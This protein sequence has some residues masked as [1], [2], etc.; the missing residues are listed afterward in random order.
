MNYKEYIDDENINVNMYNFEYW[1]PIYKSLTIQSK[2]IKLPLSILYFFKENSIYT[3]NIPIYLGNSIYNEIIKVID[4]Y[5]SVFPKLYNKCCYDGE[6]IIPKQQ[7]FSIDDI[8]ILLKSSTRISIFIS[9]NKDNNKLINEEFSL[10]LKN[11]SNNNL[12]YKDF[13]SINNEQ[14]NDINLF[15]SKESN[16]FLILKKW[17]DINADNIY[18]VIIHNGY[19]KLIIPKSALHISINLANKI[20]FL[21]ISF[22]IVETKST[23]KANNKEVFYNIL[24]N[25]IIDLII[26]EDSNRA[27]FIDIQKLD[28]KDYNNFYNE[29]LNNII[30]DNVHFT[31][32]INIHNELINIDK[33][34]KLSEISEDT[35]IIINSCIN[36][37]DVLIKYLNNKDE[38]FNNF[39]N[40]NKELHNNKYP[41]ELNDY[42]N[43]SIDELISK[44][45]EEFMQLDKN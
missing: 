23:L 16:L 20:K 3:N 43:F 22:I 25:S 17:Y 31:I 27:K 10:T 8:F 38:N 42:K 26:Y 11:N 40:F 45:N 18:K 21:I 33:K 14:K 19:I 5:N 13:I 24:N 7:C 34:I 41:I 29:Y 36:L 37:N 2:V 6:H 15:V 1:Y 39:S 28:T 35:K 12:N 32:G 9:N 4:E 30:N 44:S